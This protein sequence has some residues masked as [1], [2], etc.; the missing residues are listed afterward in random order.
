MSPAHK[1]GKTGASQAT[2]EELSYQHSVP[3]SLKPVL[4][5]I[6]LLNALQGD[7]KGE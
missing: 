6:Y 2:T 1:P 3:I 5:T 4:I 7:P